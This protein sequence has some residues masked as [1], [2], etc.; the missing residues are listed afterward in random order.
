MSNAGIYGEFPELAL[1]ERVRKVKR[2][3]LRR[4][5]EVHMAKMDAS[6]KICSFGEFNAR[7]Q[8]LETY[9]VLVAGSPGLA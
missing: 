6:P 7:L 9:S 4:I 1:F 8:S 5:S 2:G 3:D